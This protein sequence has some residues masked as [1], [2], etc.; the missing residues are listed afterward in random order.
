MPINCSVFSPSAPA[1]SYNS[2]Y[3]PTVTPLNNP[4]ELPP[5]YDSL[6]RVRQQ[7]ISQPRRN[8]PRMELL[9]REKV[10]VT[11]L[12]IRDSLRQVNN[13]FNLLNHNDT[14]KTSYVKSHYYAGQL[15]TSI[16]KNNVNKT[17]VN[18]KK[19]SK[20]ST[21]LLSAVNKDSVHKSKELMIR[22]PHLSNLR[23][24]LI[25]QCEIADKITNVIIT[26]P[27]QCA[28]ISNVIQEN[29]NKL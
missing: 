14:I 16:E 4:T 9:P 1:P 20:H 21:R 13:C 5:S 25:R 12:N 3:S 15:L 29:N 23:L 8:T 18:N 11:A 26:I 27:Q 24:K 17:L 19:I 7:T 2:V 22:S 28:N 10:L 6:T